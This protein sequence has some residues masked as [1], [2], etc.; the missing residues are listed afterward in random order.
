MQTLFTN[1]VSHELEPVRSEEHLGF[2][3]NM[4]NYERKPESLRTKER[5]KREV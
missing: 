5:K 1:A 4:T 3:I 2:S